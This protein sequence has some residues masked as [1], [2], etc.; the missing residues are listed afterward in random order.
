MLHRSMSIWWYMHL[1]VVFDL[2]HQNSIYHSML[3]LDVINSQDSR[4]KSES[5]LCI[6]NIF[7]CKFALSTTDLIDLSI[8]LM[9]SKDCRGLYSV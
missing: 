1:I 8:D 7:R 5:W 2:S 6:Y 4:N 9:D 3:L